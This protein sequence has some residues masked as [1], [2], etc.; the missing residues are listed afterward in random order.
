MLPGGYFSYT[1]V[2]NLNLH[3][4]ILTPI[5]A[6]LKREH[7]LQAQL[8]VLWEAFSASLLP[9]FTAR[10]SASQA[11]APCTNSVT[12]VTPMSCCPCLPFQFAKCEWKNE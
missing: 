10:S 12:L 3:L 6:S 2:K 1:G 4:K 8:L 7:S 5:L 11:I 9:P